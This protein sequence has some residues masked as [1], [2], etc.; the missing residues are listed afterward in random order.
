MISGRASKQSI[1]MVDQAPR[2]L[3]S[4]RW[5]GHVEGSPHNEVIL[6]LSPVTSRDMHNNQKDE[7]PILKSL[8]EGASNNSYSKTKLKRNKIEKDTTATSSSGRFQSL[9][10]RWNLAWQNCAQGDQVLLVLVV[11]ILGTSLGYVQQ[12]STCPLHKEKGI[13]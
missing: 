8:I 13:D 3:V 9:S 4:S 12:Q 11:Y 10:R 1:Q 6:K 7:D 5:E 2:A